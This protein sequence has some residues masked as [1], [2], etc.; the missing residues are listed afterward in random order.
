MNSINALCDRVC[1]SYIH[2]EYIDYI[3][4]ETRFFFFFFMHHI[5]T[6]NKFKIRLS[7]QNILFNR[8]FCGGRKQ[9][10]VSLYLYLIFEH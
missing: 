3:E 2:I 10:K 5:I 4:R 6:M 1:D 7:I 9:L 8:D